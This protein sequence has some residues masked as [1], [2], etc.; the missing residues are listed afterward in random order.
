MRKAKDIIIWVLMWLVV[1]AV[2]AAVMYFVLNSGSYPA[3]TDTMYHLYKGDL[4]Y[5]EILKGNVY[6]LLDPMWYNGVEMLRYWAPLPVY[7]LALCEALVGGNIFYGYIL[8]LGLILIFGA[9]S[10]T[11]VGYRHNRPYLGFF[12]GL[13]WFFMPNNLLA[14]FVEGNLPRALSMVFLPLF[15]SYLH[16]YL[17][18]KKWNGL[19]KL[20]VAFLLIILCHLGYAGMIV[21]AVGIFLILYGIS[22]GYWK[23]AGTVLVGMVL[24]FGITGVWSYA[25]LRGGITDTESEQVMMGFFQDAWV[26]INP[27]RR[28]TTNFSEFYF[29]LAALLTAVFGVVCS[30]KQSR[31][32]FWT[33]IIIFVLTTSGMYYVLAKLPGSQ[34]LWMLRF[35][36]IALCFILYSLFMWKSLKKGWLLLVAALLIAD[37]VPSLRLVY[38][39]GD[40][41]SL[42]T[43]LEKAEKDALIDKA[44]SIT[45]QRL[46]LMD[47]ST[48]GAMP[49]FLISSGDDGVMATFGSGWQSAATAYNIVQLNQAAE[50]GYFLYLFDRMIELG[51]DTVLISKQ[52]LGIT[53]SMV[54]RV[55]ESAIA[56][57]YEK[58]DEN[59]DFILYHLDT[60]DRFGVKT[61]YTSIAIGSSAPQMALTFP[62]MEEAESKNLNDYSYEELSKYDT[63]YIAGF[64]YDDRKSAE[65]M[66]LKLSEDGK[67][68]IILADGIP[69]VE[70]SGT[71]EFLGVQCFNINFTNGF[72]ELITKNGVLNCKPFHK[73]AR[74]WKTVYINGLD[75][76]WGTLSDLGNGLDFYGTKYNDNIIFVGLNLTY[77]YALTQDDVVGELLTDA[78]ALDSGKLPD[79]KLYPIS[80]N[81]DK[82]KIVIEA[83]ENQINTTIAFHDNFVSNNVITSKNHLTVVNSG[84]TVIKIKYPHLLAGSLITL[85]SAILTG[86][87]LYNNRKKNVI[88]ET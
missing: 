86:F 66:L 40:G 63:I 42:E 53:D 22:T 47:L 29:G 36:S 56:L 70:T 43:R 19:P 32:G 71:P 81:F 84:K 82:N 6:P 87:F 26:T 15:I 78:F 38:G 17:Y 18:E 48:L 2:A 72:P 59:K 44:K 49:G 1:G 14:I 30:K 52:A 68:I 77:H 51:T 33:G 16:D 3:G 76:V 8:Y 85:V 58:M 12:M 46:A 24:A 75:H 54:K 41:T 39:A 61:E 35:I 73:D 9:V 5:K 11:V 69:A 25:A 45:K 57:G 21:V 50:D 10:W 60:P 13:L 67:R 83:T 31:P 4:L 34:Y 80:V 65:E 27:L 23:K 20:M 79:R 37:C 88:K 28:L 64:I 55:T 74:E 62:C 7:F